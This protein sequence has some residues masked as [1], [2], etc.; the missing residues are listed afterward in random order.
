MTWHHLS[1]ITCICHCF[2][3]NTK[4]RFNVRQPYTYLFVYTSKKKLSL[5]NFL[6]FIIPSRSNSMFWHLSFQRTHHERSWGTSITAEIRRATHT[7]TPRC[8]LDYV[9][10]RKYINNKQTFIILGIFSHCL[11][12]PILLNILI[13][14]LNVNYINNHLT[15]QGQSNLFVMCSGLIN[16]EIFSTVFCCDSFC[17]SSIRSSFFIF[18]FETSKR[19]VLINCLTVYF[20]LWFVY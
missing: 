1:E 8:S 12:D 17:F 5:R 16:L 7:H 19:N 3:T 15:N 9:T 2:I 18:F 6:F 13:L 20:H 14:S 11:P 10:G 4:K